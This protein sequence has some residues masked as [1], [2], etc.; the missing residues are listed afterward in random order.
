MKL[1][2]GMTAIVTG[3]VSGLGEATAIALLERGL[4][5]VA[6]DLNDERGQAMEQKYAGR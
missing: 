6:V 4:N 3:G 2:Q 5:V 1:Q